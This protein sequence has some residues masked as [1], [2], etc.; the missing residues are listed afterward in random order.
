[1]AMLWPAVG[2]EDIDYINQILPDPAPPN[3]VLAAFWTDLNFGAGGDWRGGYLGDG[4]STWL[5]FDRENVPT[6]SGDEVDFF[7]IWIGV[8]GVEDI[9]SPMVL[10]V[11]VT[12]VMSPSVQR[13]PSETRGRTGMWMELA[14][15]WPMDLK[16]RV[17][18]VP[19]A[20]GEYLHCHL[21]CQG[22]TTREM[23]GTALR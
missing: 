18:S 13:T 20:P 12:L 6:W 5:I 1:M 9:S 17:G 2:S 10:S 7:Q 11:M 19:G 14:L 15:R 3:N 4:V 23:D 22:C 8:N 21:L 16:L